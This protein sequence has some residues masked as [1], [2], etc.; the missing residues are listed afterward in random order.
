MCGIVGYVGP[1]DA[2]PVILEGLR[3]LEYRG[4]DSAGVA[5]VQR[6]RAQRRR[7]RRASSCNLEESLRAEPLPGPFGLGHTRWATHGRPTEENAHPHQDCTGKIVVVHNGIIENYLALKTRLQ[8]A[9]PPLRDPDRHR[10]G[11]AP[12]GVALRG[13]ASRRR[14]RKALRGA[15]RASTR[16][17][18]MHRDEPQRLVAAGMGPP[19]VVGLGEGEHFLASRHPGPPALHPRLPVPRRRRGGRGDARAAPHH[20]RARARRWSASR[21][22]SPGTPC[23]R[24][25][26]ATATSC[27]R[28]STSSRG[29][30]A[31]R[32]SGASASR[33]ARSTSR[34]WAPAADALRGAERVV[35]L[36]CGTSWHAALVG[37]F[38]LE[39]VARVPAEVDYGSEFRYRTPLVGPGDAGRRRSARAARPPTPWPPSARPEARVPCPS[40]SATSRARCSPARRRARSSPTPARRSASPPPRPSPRSSWPSPCWPSTSAGCAGTL[41]RRALPRA[42]SRPGPRAPPHGAGARWPSEP[43]RGAVAQR[44]PRPR[45]FLYLGRG[46]NYPIAL[47]GALKLKEISYIHAEGYPA[48]EMK[49]GPI[50]LIDETLPVVA[51]CPPGPHLREDALQRPG[52]EGARGPRD[53]GGRRRATRSCATILE[54]E[55]RRPRVPGRATRSGRRSS[56]CSPPAP[57]LPRGG[58][59][60]ARRGPAAQPGQV[61]HG[62]VDR[63]LDRPTVASPLLAGLNPQQREAVLAT[64]GPVLI[65]A[66]AGSGKTRVITHRIA[67]LVL[68]KGVPSE[69]I[70]AV[71][72]T[73][74]AAGEM[75]A[76]AEALLGGARSTSWISTFHSFCVRLLRREAAAAGLPPGL[77]D[78]RRGRPAGGGARGPAGAGPLGEAPPPAAH[79]V[80]HLGA[81]ELRARRR[82]TE[83]GLGRRGD[84]GPRRRALPADRSQAAGALDFDDLLLKRGRPARGAT[85]R[86]ASAYRR[87]FRYVLVDEYQDTNRAQ[88][89]LVRLLAGPAGQPHRGGR[90]GPVDLLLARRRH[91][92]HPRLRARLPGRAGPAPGGELP[93]EPG[94]PRRRLRASWP[95][96]SAAR[97]RPCAR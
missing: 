58:A 21:S 70:L 96:T 55:R 85:R 53:R 34:S 73:N 5:V 77:R 35:L 87:R 12:G 59:R 51:L 48:G 38:L 64:D 89:E 36:A 20:R 33:R 86:C 17:C 82:R 40:P 88:Y 95:T 63:R 68:D 6:R 67:H 79:P 72:F 76:R 56:W 50:A 81:Q 2:V 22:G 93:L 9:G 66:G 39:Q 94:H 30:C 69:P 57:G 8:A 13:L 83:G 78:L 52:G 62:R 32:C 4:Y 91:P 25:R 16:W 42:R 90:R 37:K 49:H 60:G 61:R 15:A 31:T 1:R 7:V 71:T 3:R 46:V 11:R 54:P 19:L 14:V 41:S 44:S 45:D 18:C 23:R 24:R 28:R 65:L 27:S 10:G 29:R 75:K 92:E 74:K 97:A 47:E 84:L 26:A 43:H 80:A